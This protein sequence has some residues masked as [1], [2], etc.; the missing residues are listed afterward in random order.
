MRRELN[1]KIH[2]LHKMN[3]VHIRKHR[4]P[5]HLALYEIHC[6][7]VEINRTDLWHIMSTS[8]SVNVISW[9]S[10]GESVT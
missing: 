10:I 3:E 9:N 6:L 8:Q 4:N 7:K 5:Q 1:I 2:E